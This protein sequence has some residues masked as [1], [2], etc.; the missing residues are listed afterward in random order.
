MDYFW[1]RKPIL[2]RKPLWAE[3]AYSLEN[4]LLS[5]L[6]PFWKSKLFQPKMAYFPKLTYLFIILQSVL[7][8]IYTK[9]VF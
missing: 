3:T 8:P 7:I 6:S 9:L 4:S 1:K 2:E 5:K